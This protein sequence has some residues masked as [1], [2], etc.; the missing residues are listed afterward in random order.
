MIRDDMIYPKMLII[1]HARHG[2]DTV[3]EI[4]RDEYG[5]IFT[6]SS[7]FCADRVVMPAITEWRTGISTT[8][9]NIVTGH[10]GFPGQARRPYASAEECYEDRAN[11]R[12]LWFDLISHHNREDA[13]RLAGDILEYHDVYVG[14]RSKREFHA[15]VNE[16]LADLVVWVDRSDR[17]PLEPKS[18]MQLEPW[19]ADYV[20][21]NNGS[22]A[23]LRMEVHR[24]VMS[25]LHSV[26]ENHR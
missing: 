12:A 5:F 11:H 19:M 4:L 16:G 7:L 8:R 13:A 22:L 23:E 1:G 6:S 18:S 24:L 3:A 17:L 21:D 20:I 25:R 10:W 26:A 14:I 15:A 2:K 9:T